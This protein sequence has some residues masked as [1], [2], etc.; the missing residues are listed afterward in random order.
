MENVQ[1]LVNEIRSTISQKTSSRKDEIKVMRA[2]L[3]DTNYKVGVYDKNGLS[4]YYCPAESAKSMVTSILHNSAGLS[5]SEAGVLAKN[6]EFSK[7]DAENM[8][9]I[10]KEFIGTYM[11]TNRKIAFGGR[12][13]S[14]ISIGIKEIESSSRPFPKVVGVD[15]NGKKIYGRGV[16][17]ISGYESMKVYAPCPSWIKNK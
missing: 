16:T 3:N 5:E 15:S 17:E 1:D 14:D 7:A 11:H 10:S 4:G 6:Y 13:K 12:E 9:D 8:L 2:M